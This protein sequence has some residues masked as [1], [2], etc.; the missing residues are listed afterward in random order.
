LNSVQTNDRQQ[1][2]YNLVFGQKFVTAQE[3]NHCLCNLKSRVHKD[4]LCYE[5]RRKIIYL[6]THYEE[7]GHLEDVSLGGSVK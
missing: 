1:I 4:S 6:C 3:V 2:Q 5:L 7:R